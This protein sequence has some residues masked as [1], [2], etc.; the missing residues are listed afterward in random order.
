VIDVTSIEG[1]LVAVI[2]HE[3][4]P[5]SFP[6]AVPYDYASSAVAAQAYMPVRVTLI[7]VEPGALN[8]FNAVF[9]S[10]EIDFDSSASSFTRADVL[11]SYVVGVNR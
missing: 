2:F 3:S 1:P 10:G 11:K 6:G 7:N 9:S 8:D 4:S 5:G